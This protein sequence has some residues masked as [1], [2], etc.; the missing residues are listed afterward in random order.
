MTGA[1]IVLDTLI[2]AY[3]T[4]S[5]FDTVTILYHP[6]LFGS[7]SNVNPSPCFTICP[8]Y[9]ISVLF[10]PDILSDTLT[11][12]LFVSLLYLAIISGFPFPSCLPIYSINFCP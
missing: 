7:Y 4:L 6:V 2:H 8:L 9:I 1:N 11:S 12:I 10:I 3:L 5:L